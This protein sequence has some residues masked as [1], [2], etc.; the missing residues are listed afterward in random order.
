MSELVR[1]A[2]VAISAPALA[3][4]WARQEQ[5]PSGAAVTVDTEIAGRLRGGAEWV[6]DDA[7]AVTVI[8]RPDDL[9]PSA[10][11][12]AWL[13]TGL[14]GREAAAALSRVLSGGAE[15]SGISGPSGGVPEPV[16]RWPDAVVGPDLPRMVAAVD[17]SLGPGRVEYV[18]ATV[19]LAPVSTM[20]TANVDLDRHAVGLTVIESLRR[21]LETLN[22]PEQLLAEYRRHCATLSELVAV[23]LL[24]RGTLKGRAAGIS[25][26]GGLVVESSTGLRQVVAV[27]EVGEVSRLEERTA[28]D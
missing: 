27:G 12:L 28:G 23:T 15:P 8:A 13:A 2:S 24:P 11:D 14:A 6:S 17:A 19:R 25:D 18:V 16:C 4:Q 3:H 1:H 7:V 5:A 22:R 9:S 21:W 20:T 26:S 10:T